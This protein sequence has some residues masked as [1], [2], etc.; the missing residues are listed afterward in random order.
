M[1]NGW[2]MPTILKQ[3]IMIL[4]D[5][6]SLYGKKEFDVPQFEGYYNR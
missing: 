5:K 6:M 3:I 1:E 2:L 4:K